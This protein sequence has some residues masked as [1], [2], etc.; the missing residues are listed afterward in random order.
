MGFGVKQPRGGDG[1]ER[2][3]AKFSTFLIGQDLIEVDGRHHH[4]CL[5]YNEKDGQITDLAFA[6]LVGDFER[7]E[8]VPGT[9][10]SLKMEPFKGKISLV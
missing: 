9:L 8:T 5:I 6:V 1:I 2:R 7:V 10:I 3:R 4:Y